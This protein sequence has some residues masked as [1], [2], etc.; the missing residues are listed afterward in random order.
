MGSELLV[1][2]LV[3]LIV[4]GPN[5]LPMLAEHLG[6]LLRHYNHLKQQLADFWQGQVAEQELRENEKK[7]EKVDKEGYGR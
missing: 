5:K 6:K 7:A 2:L 3:A 4:F 1:I